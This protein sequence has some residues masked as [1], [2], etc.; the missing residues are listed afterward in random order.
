MANVMFKRGLA[1]DLNKATVVDG[2]FYLT[3]DTNR[4]YVGQGSNLVE[5]NKS[6][7][8]VANIAA[9]PTTN[10]AKGQF[11]YVVD[12]NILAYYNG[13]GWDQI[14]PDTTLT[15]SK[16]NISVTGETNKAT[17]KDTITD[18]KG[19]T[20]EGSFSVAGDDAVTVTANGTAITV[21]A[22][23]TKYDLT[24]EDASSG[25]VSAANIVLGSDVTGEADTKVKIIG[26]TNISVDV[27]EDG[28]IEIAADDAANM[29]NTNVGI[30]FDAEGKQTV[31][32]TDGAGTKFASVTPTITYGNG[33][34]AKFISG[35]A[36]LDVYDKAQ[37]D[38]I[39]QAADA[40]HYKGTVSKEDAATKLVITNAQIGDVY[41]ASETID[42]PVNA[43]KGDLIIAYGTTEDVNGKLTSDGYWEVITSGDDQLITVTADATSN[44]M[45][46]NDNGV[47]LGSIALIDGGENVKVTS[48][49]ANGNLTTTIAHD[50]AGAAVDANTVS[51]SASDV[52]Q[53]TQSTAEFE[54][55]TKIERDA[56]GHI[57]SV[58]KQKI[59]VTD[60]HNALNSVTTDTSA[61]STTG[62]VKVTTTVAT[63]DG[64]KSDEFE[65]KSETITLAQADGVI[66]ADLVWG[67]F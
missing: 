56:N 7:T 12:K 14:N 58:G 20:S 17:V 19:N 65:I 13:T 48:T 25:D 32:V 27:Q 62:A 41:K 57:V 23:D 45:S 9:L 1:A 35:T 54:A 10:V 60:T 11:Y 4:L 18:S 42:S 47:A 3:T 63:T 61:G 31:S 44:K 49:V 39:V 43:N 5:L 8:E 2:A 59:T 26:G 51:G 16:A 55:I 33:K 28:S 52:T 30:G 67:S 38:Q 46:V 21:K 37:V 29:Y 50:V 40:L 53:A 64:S 6:I 24:T 36:A 34:T 15:A 66:S 22:H